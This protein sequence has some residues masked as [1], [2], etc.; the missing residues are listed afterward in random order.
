M[1]TYTE[2]RDVQPD[3]SAGSLPVNPAADRDLHIKQ[4]S[5]GLQTK[6]PQSCRHCLFLKLWHVVELAQP[7]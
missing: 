5:E 4:N 2:L 3:R 6:E 7:P 1:L